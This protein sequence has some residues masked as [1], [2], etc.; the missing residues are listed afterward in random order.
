MGELLRS[1]HAMRLVK[2]H[3]VFLRSKVLRMHQ[4]SSLALTCGLRMFSP[5]PWATLAQPLT[6]R[7]APRT[8][9]RRAVDM[10]VLIETA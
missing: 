7:S 9:S 2:Q 8:L 6:S 1:A 5:L 3:Q 4:C 10:I